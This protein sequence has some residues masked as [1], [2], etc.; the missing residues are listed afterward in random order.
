MDCNDCIHSDVCEFLRQR[1]TSNSV[2]CEHFKDINN[3][4]KIVNC[5]DCIWCKKRTNIKDDGVRYV[6][7]NPYGKKKSLMLIDYCS[8]G[9]R[10]ITLIDKNK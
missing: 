7:T 6:C 10:K 9:K 2:E 3:F 5:N 1:A 8:L 4:V